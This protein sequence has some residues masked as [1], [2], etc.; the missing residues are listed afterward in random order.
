MPIVST[1]SHARKAD[2]DGTIIELH[3]VR[4]VGL[5]VEAG[6]KLCKSSG[7]GRLTAETLQHVELTGPGLQILNGGRFRA[8]PTCLLA[9]RRTDSELALAIVRKQRAFFHDIGCNVDH[10]DVNW[11]GRIQGQKGAYDLVGDFSSWMAKKRTME[12]QE[13]CG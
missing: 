12:Q 8:V 2:F 1:Y 5:A 6:H 9:L 3:P 4:A 13:K 11:P 7:L 10:V